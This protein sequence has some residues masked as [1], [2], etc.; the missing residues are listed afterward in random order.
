MMGFNKEDPYGIHNW[1]V[2][3]ILFCHTS[4]QSAHSS[5]SRE[6]ATS[7]RSGGGMVAGEST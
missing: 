6:H 1:F 4:G 7:T 5:P 2:K 3:R